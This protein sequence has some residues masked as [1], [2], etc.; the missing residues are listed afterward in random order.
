MS[1]A[2]GLPAPLSPSQPI[3]PLDYL[4][5]A[6]AASVLR[7]SVASTRRWVK[8]GRLSARQLPGAHGRYLIP[9]TAL[10]MLLGDEVTQ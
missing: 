1:Q 8:S 7:V 9:R 4:T 6:E 5:L 2:S 10:D 3:P